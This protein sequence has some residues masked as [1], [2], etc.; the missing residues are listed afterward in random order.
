M[1]TTEHTSLYL[2]I[3]VQPCLDG[4]NF[5]HSSYAL[6]N[7][8]EVIEVLHIWEDLVIESSGR[9]SVTMKV[10]PFKVSVE[11]IK[12]FIEEKINISVNEQHLRL[13]GQNI[14]EIDRLCDMFITAKS[15]PVIKVD[16]D[17]D[18]NIKVHSHSG[19]Q[20]EVQINWF[21]TVNDLKEKLEQQGISIDTLKF[22][23]AEISTEGRK[24]LID[25]DFKPTNAVITVRSQQRSTHRGFSASA[26]E[27]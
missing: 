5:F 16:K 3:P 15:V 6:E 9:D 1:E 27:G 14:D 24:Q 12:G 8:N 13:S 23:D 10:D 2:E 21:A 26:F 7:T 20:Q 19:G 17:R 4:F 22:K 18:I 11:E 25:L